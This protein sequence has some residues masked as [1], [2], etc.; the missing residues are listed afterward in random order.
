M[1]GERIRGLLVSTVLVAIALA[2]L[3]FMVNMTRV[4]IS[5]LALLGGVIGALS[6]YLVSN[7]NL[8]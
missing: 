1:T 5:V 3:A 8:D 7:G 4:G 2:Y 6:W